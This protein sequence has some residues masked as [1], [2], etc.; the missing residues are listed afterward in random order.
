MSIYGRIQ[1]YIIISFLKKPTEK[2]QKESKKTTKSIK[3][4]N[5]S[6]N[7]W[8]KFHWELPARNLQNQ[9]ICQ[10]ISKSNNFEKVSDEIPVKD[11]ERILRDTKPDW[12]PVRISE[13]VLWGIPMESSHSISGEIFKV[14]LQIFLKETLKKVQLEALAESNPWS[15]PCRN[16]WWYAWRI[17]WSFERT[18]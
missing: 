6:T 2:F 9:E 5:S 15:N 8:K 7:F 11:A 16:S 14:F 1:E 18:S 3:I 17:I 10:N 12:I 4:K 13:K